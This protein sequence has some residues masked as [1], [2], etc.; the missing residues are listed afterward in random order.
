MACVAAQ[1]NKVGASYVAL[2][3]RMRRECFLIT[4][5]LLV[6]AAVAAQG[7]VRAAM[8]AAQAAAGLMG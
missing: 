3:Q 8:M 1:V 2:R 4:A 5:A 6:L 7:A